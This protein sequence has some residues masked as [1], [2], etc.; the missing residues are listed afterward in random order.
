MD[1]KGSVLQGTD[2]V[3]GT[4]GLDGRPGE[5]GPRGPPVCQRHVNLLNDIFNNTLTIMVWYDF[6]R[7][8]SCARGDTICSPAA[9]HPL[10]LRCPARLA[11]NSCG[12]HEY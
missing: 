7:T 1:Y 8:T 11:S 5:I 2:G 10:R 6:V 3:P 12:R 4:P 9:A